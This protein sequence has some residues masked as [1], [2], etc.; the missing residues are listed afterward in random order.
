MAD[1]QLDGFAPVD[2]F[3]DVPGLGVG[4]AEDRS[5]L[6]GV[7]VI[8]P[9]A[10]MTMAVDVRGGGPATRET[11]ALAPH[12][13]VERV[14]AL[15]LSGG[16]MFGLAA[17]DAVAVTLSQSGIGLAAGPLPIPV[18]PAACLFDMANGGDKTWV[19]PPHRALG[20]TALAACARPDSSGAAGAGFGAIAGSRPGGIGSV[21]V[22]AHGFTVGALVAV[23]SFGEVYPGAPP[24]DA[25]ALPK[26]ARS[27]G[28]SA[29]S[30]CIGAVATD[31][32][33][34]RAQAQRVA[35]MAHDGLARAI[36]PIHTPFDGDAIFAI[37][38]GP[39]T[40][41]DAV[42]LAIIGTLAAD[43]V[44]RAVRRAVFGN[45]GA[46]VAAADAAA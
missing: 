37:S 23:N 26:L 15:V 2:C 19:E 29:Q 3:T 38:T 13:L 33:L 43:C 44:A 1:E 17:A 46:A 36:R 31:A 11:D 5:A 6:T 42:A 45:Q 41:V 4:H 18:V 16:S 30:T 12:T 39:A 20:R 9:D 32:P 25:V 24:E 35:M 40:G 34:T 22:R 28:L 7:T 14:H 8:L 10:P 27:G 21:S